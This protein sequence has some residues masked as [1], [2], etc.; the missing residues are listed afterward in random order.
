MK[1]GIACVDAMD[2]VLSHQYN[3]RRVMHEIAGKTRDVPYQLT[4]NGS[5]PI[6]RQEQVRTGR[7]QYALEKAPRV[8]RRERS[9][10]HAGVR[11]YAHELVADPPG[12]VPRGLSGTPLLQLPAAFGVLIGVGV[13]GVDENIGIDD[14]HSGLV[15]IGIQC[16]AIGDIYGGASGA[17]RRQQW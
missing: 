16:F 9:L 4:Q 7:S 2:S 15:Q 3:R 12:Q 8:T 13:R 11:R 1:I 10:E 6:G 14:K 5:V 17:E